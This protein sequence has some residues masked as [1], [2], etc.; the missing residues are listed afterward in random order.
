MP[1][2]KMYENVT[3]EQKRAMTP[4]REEFFSALYDETGTVATGR[5]NRSNGALAGSGI[6]FRAEIALV[7]QP[8]FAHA[9]LV[10]LTIRWRIRGDAILRGRIRRR[11]RLGLVAARPGIALRMARGTSQCGMSH[12]RCLQGKPAAKPRLQNTV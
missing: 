11:R 7:F 9:T 3:N 4:H 6:L 2:I 10:V 1:E 8:L 5:Q 12:D